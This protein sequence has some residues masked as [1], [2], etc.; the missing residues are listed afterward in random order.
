VAKDPPFSN[1]DLISCRNVLIYLNSLLQGRVLP[2]F[3]YALKPDRF[4]LLGGSE[5]IHGFESL[6]KP[7]D[8][9]HKIYMKRD[10]A[11]R[12]MVDFSL[13]DYPVGKPAPPHKADTDG[14]QKF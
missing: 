13:T 5:T 7:L 3:H 9:K 6:F 10:A 2:I 1:L 4:L 12:P 11:R 8:R 14:N